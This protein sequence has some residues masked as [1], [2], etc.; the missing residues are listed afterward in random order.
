M[1]NVA[2]E[3]FLLLTNVSQLKNRD[4][5]IDLFIEGLCVIFTGY[6]FKWFSENKE[7]P[8][9]TLLVSTR[10]KIYGHIHF[11]KEISLDKELYSLFYNSVQLVSIFLERLEQD[12]LLSSQISQIQSSVNEQTSRLIEKKDELSEMNEELIEKNKSL[13]ELNQQLEI[14]IEVRKK[15]EESLAE[16]E[17]HFRTL[18]DSGQALIWTSGIDK[19]CNYFNQ[20]WLNFTGR[21]LEQELGDGWVEGVHPDDLNHCVEIYVNA[22]DRREK[23][24]MEYRI[25]NLNGEYHWIQDDGTPRFNS[26]GEFIGYIG[27]CLD[28]ND[29][30]QMEIALRESEA[31]YQ[32]VEA[33]GHVGNWEYNLQ[34]S[35]FWG[36]DEAKRIYGFDQDST[37]FST[38]E[39]ENCIPERDRVHQALI[40]LIE[41]GKEYNL[42]IEILHRNSGE[43][44][45]ILSVAELERDKLGNPL[46]VM[47]V[48]QDITARKKA[49][50]ALLESETRF[51]SFVENANDIVYSLSLDGIFTYVSPNWKELL[52]HE[53]DEVIGQSFGIFVHPDDIQK[54]LNVLE[55]SITMGEK[56]SGIEYRVLHKNGSWRWHTTNSSPILNANNE[57]FSSIGI[58]RDITERKKMEVELKIREERLSMIMDAT[59]TGVWDWDLVNDHWYASPLYYEMLGY[60]SVQGESDRRV[61]LERIHPDDREAVSLKISKVLSGA[62]KEYVYDARMRHADGSYRWHSVQGY[63]TSHDPSGNV[64]RM[65][66]TRID[67][68]ERKKAER[69]LNESQALYH[70]FVEHLPA[71]VFRKDSQGRYVFVNTRFCQLKGLAPEEIIGKT[72]N[73]LSDYEKFMKPQ[74]AFDTKGIQRTIADQGTDHHI[75]IMK[76]GRPIEL[77]EEYT[78]PDGTIKY[79]QVIKSPVFDADGVVIGSQGVQLDITERR[80]AEEAIRDSEQL[81]SNIFYNSPVAMSITSRGDGK[82]VDVNDTFLRDLEFERDEMVGRSIMELGIFFD[83]ESR[84][85]LIDALLK[86]GFVTGFECPFLTK[87]G[88]T[89]FGLLSMTFIHYKGKPHQL[90]TVIDITERRQTE[91][92][93]RKSEARFSTIFHTSPTP[94]I[95]SEI[96]TGRFI[97]FNQQW[98]NMIGYSSEEMIGRTSGELNIFTDYAERGK[99]IDELKMKGYVKEASLNIITKS[100][101]IKYVLWSIEIINLAGDD[102]ILSQLH[103]ITQRKKLELEIIEKQ[104][105]VQAILDASI[106]IVALVND[107]GEFLSCNQKLIQRWNR[108]KEE[109][110]GHSAAEILPPHI[111]RNRVE[112]IN[113]VVKT[114]ITEQFVDGFSDR[115]YEVVI[116]PI[117]EANK[118]VKNVALFSRDVTEN[119]KADEELRKLQR[120]VEQSP[121]SII[122]TSS[123]GIIEYANP[124][125]LKL[126]GYSNEELIGKN[127]R[128]FSSGEKS[129]DE[130]KIL[131]DTVG[132]GNVWQGEFLNKKKNGELYWESSTISPVIDDT[133]KITHYLAIS[134]D[135]TEQ[136][137]L[138][139]ELIEAKEH[140]EESDRLKESFLANMSHEIRTPMNSIMGFASLLPEENSKELMSQ[141]AQIIVQ[142]SEQLVSIIDG[143]VLYSKLQ[144]RLFAFHPKLFSVKKLLDD[145]QLSFNL[146]DFQNGVKLKAEY[147]IPIDTMIESDYDKIRQVFTNLVSNAFK[148]TVEGVITIGFMKEE[149][150][151]KF[152]VSDTGIGIPEKD[153]NQIFERFY[154]GSNINSSAIRGTGLG[155]SI[156]KELVELLGGKIWVESELGRGSTFFFT[157]SNEQ[158]LKTKM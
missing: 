136:K 118:S 110:I 116:V 6:S 152:Y 149:N 121:D 5:V 122:I 104:H 39:V 81:F 77:I 32:K 76:T 23:F 67:I 89:M 31:R 126:T 57:V 74:R 1:N 111:F 131:W 117:F 69:L 114:G 45:I 48:I 120:A 51:R 97:D 26:K 146:P 55:R 84:T 79:F 124:A 78:Q 80:L 73:E 127:P 155:L 88:R 153:K 40:D 4:R 14:E 90:T 30:K 142:N 91:E 37:D 59:H 119:M 94:T 156:V 98:V 134:E 64:T 115:F 96:S 10:S 99:V 8:D 21:K 53:V 49:E 62:E 101:E 158:F 143:I 86:D 44:R 60:E 103:D 83:V 72:P 61:W 141:Y 52:G 125:I 66:G 137:K 92:A 41:T 47:G 28:I 133:G 18:A 100:G 50:K 22:F 43:S 139:R 13:L 7:I 135:V 70:S 24:S 87:N 85:K 38:D 17:T 71:S 63:V 35:Q 157:V 56:Q 75:R 144:T 29:R 147:T 106:D 3:V 82:I 148:Y 42:E 16:S 95:I 27:H 138:T 129:K 140:A 150:L 107:K 68:S 145:V 132:S 113:R 108:P 151:I 154:R 34:T 112:S 93:L 54:C 36:S 2:L 109:L 11:S 128:I 15:L 130:Y 20:P 58:A 65:I 19:K 123:N 102:V 46:T 12:E 9:S 25:R 33:I 105:E